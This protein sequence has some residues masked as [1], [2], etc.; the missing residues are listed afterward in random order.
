M[1]RIINSLRADAGVSAIV[2]NHIYLDRA[3]DRNR[4]PYLVITKVD[5]MPHNT[6]CGRSGQ[7]KLM[8]D[9]D[10]YTKSNRKR[11]DL[12]KALRAW[13]KANNKTPDMA[14]VEIRDRTGYDNLREANHGLIEFH[15]WL[16]S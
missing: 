13:G 16:K 1:N 14:V 6:F 11:D 4:H 12:L 7:D 2:N 9:F 5:N 3:N 10:F 15:I 8:V